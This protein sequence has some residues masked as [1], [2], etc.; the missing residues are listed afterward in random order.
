MNL[1]KLLI[2]HAGVDSFLYKR[3]LYFITNSPAFNVP[4]RGGFNDIAI[5][6]PNSPSVYHVISDTHLQQ[7]LTRYKVKEI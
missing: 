7:Q 6:R 3:L 2:K 5:K 1:R 4:Q